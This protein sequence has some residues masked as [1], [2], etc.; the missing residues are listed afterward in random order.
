MATIDQQLPPEE[1]E[2]EFEGDALEVEQTDGDEA[3]PDAG[4]RPKPKRLRVG[5]ALIS[6]Y[7]SR[8]V[9]SDRSIASKTL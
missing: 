8:A 7:S 9:L 3:A 1:L 6:W 2:P 5:L 4:L